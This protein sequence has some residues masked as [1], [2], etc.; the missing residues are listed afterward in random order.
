M[1][2]LRGKK[3]RPIKDPAPSKWKYR[4]QRWMLTPSFVTSIR[5]GVPVFLLAVLATSFFSNPEN[6]AMV[7]AKLKNTRIA[8]QNRPEF[9]VGRLEVRGANENVAEQVDRVVQVA[10]PISSFNLDLEEIKTNVT[11]LSTVKE[12]AVKVGEGGALVVEVSPRVPVAIWRDG[13]VLNLLDA[14]GIFSGALDNRG[15]R[16]DLPLIAGEGAYAS[17]DEALALFVRS[18]PLGDRV[19]GLVRMGER[20]W[21]MVLDRDQRILLPAEEPSKA[22]DRI[23]VLNEAHD[24]LSRDVAVLDMRNGSRPT[25][26]V[27][28][29]AANALRRVSER[30]ASE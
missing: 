14:D 16:A 4:L 30:G 13:G 28:Q 23:I 3:T 5:V 6:K 11:A 26:R 7:E 9:M 18:A 29:E 15:D 21:D 20:R 25:V 27:T 19:R 17:I 1:R 12:A 22:L 8:L 10:F 2:A 24:L